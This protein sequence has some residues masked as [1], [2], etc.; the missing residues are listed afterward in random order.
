MRRGYFLFR[1]IF[2]VCS[3]GHALQADYQSFK[4][5]LNAEYYRR[6]AENSIRRRKTGKVTHLDERV[7][8]KNLKI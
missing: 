5:G 8:N 3:I 7:T 1:F 4:G 6:R 2:L